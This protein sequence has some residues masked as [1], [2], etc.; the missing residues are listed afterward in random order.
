MFWRFS[1][2]R[3]ASWPNSLSNWDSGPIVLVLNKG[4]CKQARAGN[5]SFS[6]CVRVNPRMSGSAQHVGPG[7]DSPAWMEASLWRPGTNY[8]VC[9]WVALNRLP[10]ELPSSVFNVNMVITFTGNN[11]RGHWCS[12]CHICKK[13]CTI[14]LPWISICVWPES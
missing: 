9:A 12:S 4:T 13:C 2:D 3:E 11:R 10:W 8:S 6:V 7:V 5:F 1:V 14:C